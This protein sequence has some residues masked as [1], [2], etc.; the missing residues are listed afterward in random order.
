M[1]LNEGT[2]PPQRIREA[3]LF[4]ILP[5]GDTSSAAEALR[6]LQLLADTAE[7]TVGGCMI[8]HRRAPDPATYLGR[9]KLDEL[10]E[11]VEQSKAAV[12][13]CDDPLSPAQ[14]RNVEK[15]VGKPVVDRSELILEIFGTHA[16]TPQARLQ[17][18]LAALQ[19]EMPRLKRMWTHLERQRGGIGL[20]GGAGEKQIDIDRNLLRTRIAQITREL[21]KIE[22]RK[23]RE[24]RAR[25]DRFTLALVGYTNAGK[26]S[27]MNRLTEA[28]VVTEDRLFSTLDTRTRPWRLPGGR[29]VLLSDT[30]GFIRKLPHQLVASF[31]ATLE[32][33]L[34]A[35]LLL[36]VVD[37]SSPEGTEQMDAV[38]DV[39]EELDVAHLPRIL[40]INKIDIVQDRSLIAE[41]L[42]REPDAVPVSAH[43]GEGLEDLRRNLE[44]HMALVERRVEILV[45]HTAGHV[46]AEIRERA[47]V[48]SELFTEEGSL[49]E[50]VVSPTLLGMLLARGALLPD[51]GS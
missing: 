19:Y 37:G 50:I 1:S 30:V 27:L 4:G 8:Q 20:R 24:I 43:T 29:T 39:L 16:Q 9:G 34:H 26:S 40:L 2:E 3:I 36:L 10:A 13:L 35:D 22:A 49:M 33:A 31:H 44:E 41:L 17:V 46:R 11:V 23:S 21:A 28:G 7:Y 38:L 42:L 12:V 15:A 51:E 5:H 14:G 25:P 47:T 45:P 48:I 18:E 6:E 32:E